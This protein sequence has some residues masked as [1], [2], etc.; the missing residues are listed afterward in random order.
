MNAP[1]KLCIN[2]FHYDD[3]K[4]EQLK[5]GIEIRQNNE[6]LFTNRNILAMLS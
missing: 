6:G 5:K 1:L 4:T 2:S 3:K